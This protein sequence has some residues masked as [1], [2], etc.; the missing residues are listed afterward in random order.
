M[1]VSVDQGVP[2]IFF[3]ECGFKGAAVASRALGKDY[4][5]FA[6]GSEDPVA[7]FWDTRVARI[8]EFGKV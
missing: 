6:T 2:L 5:Y 3:Q 7:T 4:I 8:F 1:C